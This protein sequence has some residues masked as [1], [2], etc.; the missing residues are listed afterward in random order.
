[1]KRFFLILGVLL[2][3]AGGVFAQ[4]ANTVIQF[5]GTYIYFNDNSGHLKKTPVVPFNFQ[6][7]NVSGSCFTTEFAYTS[8]GSIYVCI[9]NTWTLASSSGGSS[10]FASITAG[11]NTTTLVIGTG[12]SLSTT[13]SGTITATAAPWSGLTG[14][15]SAC[16]TSN[17]VNTIGVTP[18][19]SQP[20]FT[21]IS[22]LLDLTSQITGNLPVTNL[23]SGTGA[24]S[25]TF[26]R[27]DGTWATPIGSSA[28]TTGV[29]GQP[30]AYNSTAT[31]ASV[32][33]AIVVDAIA[34]G[35]IGQ[36]PIAWVSSTTYP[37]CQVV[38]NSGNY[39]ATSEV[40]GATTPGTN[41]HVWYPI[42]NGSR[43]T[44]Y[45]CA[46]YIAQARVVAAAGGGVDLQLGTGV[47]NSCIGMTYPTMGGIGLPGVNIHGV[48]VNSSIINQTCTLLSGSG[49]DGLAMLNIPQATTSFFL[50]RLQFSNFTLEGNAIVPAVFDL[51]ACQQC[52]VEHIELRDGAPNT[53]HFMEIGTVGGN[54]T[55][56]VYELTMEDVTTSYNA[57][58]TG[59]GHGNGAAAFSVTVSGGVPTITVTNGGA[60]YDTRQMNFRLVKTGGLEACS[61]VGTFTPTVVSGVITALTTTST[62]CAATG[63]TFVQIYPQLSVQYSFKFSNMSDSHF[64]SDLIPGGVGATAGVFISNISSMNTFYKLHPIGTFNGVSNAGNNDF[65]T[66][67]MD[68]VYNHA[69]DE[70]GSNDTV[71]LYG[72]MFEWNANHYTG[73]S[74]YFIAKTSGSPTNAPAA[75]NIYGDICGNKASQD[76][77]A[78]IVAGSGAVDAGNALPNFVTI[79]GGTQYCNNIFTNTV[80]FDNVAQNVNW[81]NGLQSNF[82][83]WNLGSSGNTSLTLTNSTGNP[84]TLA[85]TNSNAAT[86]GAN[87]S[88]PQLGLEGQYWDGTTT[89]LYGPRFR[90]TFAAGTEP[91]ATFFFDGFGT[92]TTGG[93]IW[94]FDA[95][96]KMGAAAAATTTTN[97]LFIYDST[98]NNLHVGANGVDNINVVV[99]SSVSIT[100]T[101]CVNWSK[102]GNVITLGDA[103]SACGSGGG[104][105]SNPMTTLGDMI[106]GGASGT[107]SR[108]TGPTGPN[109]LAQ[110]LTSVPSSSLAVAPSWALPGVSGRAVTGIT[111]TDSILSTDCS[112][113]RIE[114]VGSVAVAIT[115]PTA[116]TLAVPSCVFRVTNNTSGSTTALTITPTTWTINGS[117]TLTVAQGQ[118]ATIY[119]DPNSAT[120]WV[121]D[122]T[123]QGLIAGTNISFTRSSLGLTINGAACSVCVTSAASLTNNSVVLGAGSQASQTLT[124]FTTDG[125]KQLNLGFV[126][127]GGS[128]VLGLNGSTSGTATITAPAVAGTVANPF[129]FS[130]GGNFGGFLQNTGGI[131]TD[132]SHSFIWANRSQMASGADGIITFSNNAQNNFTRLTLGPDSTSFPALCPNGTG[133]KIG[134]AAAACTTLTNLQAGSV[135]L[136][137]LL[138]SSTAPTI[139]SGFNTSG[140]SISAPNGTAAFLVT[141]GSGT[142]TSTGVIG[143]PTATTGWNCFA[144]NQSRADQIQETTSGTTSVTL[145]N[146]GTTFSATNFTNSDVLQVSC[147]AY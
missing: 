58:L 53:D 46:F 106:Y 11:T 67:Q 122:V 93:H 55:G 15:P 56:W 147:F 29:I 59:I 71:N 45:D 64:I 68:S 70:E 78:H 62:G 103:G 37:L 111:S 35:G 72:T 79:S 19:C 124:G 100:N 143:L 54:N 121:A 144:T 66:L 52:V 9:N 117:S 102:V 131:Q 63:S 25:T 75:I 130:N 16:S 22:G 60:N 112:P 6:A 88:S 81:S 48:G 43:P 114:Y 98:N 47:Y 87:R 5:D 83:T 1:M 146:F 24:A 36:A 13:G 51:H 8:A 80:Q 138:L 73:S 101:D 7:G 18:T 108:L 123:E 84:W 115:L 140:F 28:V 139:T 30:S 125:S 141:V 85:Y 119:V 49:G 96:V 120:N 50:P 20:A 21:D 86:S 34:G 90:A 107:A 133:V 99:P 97:G 132:N 42:P 31:V 142:G 17:W 128:G 61:S 105:F 118:I 109:N 4:G 110:I 33:T 32:P 38:S 89:Q 116:T 69:F 57:G 10:G 65:F 127:V 113:N 134:R 27:G 136:T 91:L 14:F 39:I 104:G 76:A 2:C 41:S 74:D 44:K 82:W 126:G 23:G 12:G 40:N 3:L 129:V 137:T 77:Y 94:S 145:T 92:A 26:W 95:G 135:S